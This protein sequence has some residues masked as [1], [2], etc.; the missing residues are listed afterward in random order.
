MY[1]AGICGH[2]GFGKDLANGQTVKTKNITS[3]LEKIYGEN[4]IYKMDSSGGKKQI[5]KICTEA[6]KLIKKCENIIMLPAHN[7]LLIFT[8]LFRFYNILFKRKLHYVV[9][10]GWLPEYMEK[11]KVTKRL[12][13]GFDK[14]Y[15]ETS[16]MKSKLENQGFNNVLVMPNF[17]HIK[18]IECK[19]KQIGL[20][21]KL[22]T[23]SRVLYEK[24]IEHAIEAVRLINQNGVTKCI[25]DIYGDVD[26][27]YK[28]HFESICNELPEY[29]RYMGCAD[30]QK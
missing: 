2:F 17:K 1:K 18:V 12:L 24:G 27:S 15:V 10:G 3:E 7:G 26:V 6:F 13:K 25:L 30:S 16:M 20:P 19:A 22:C 14:I 11:H 4:L 8:P 29:I 5:L 21:F 23:F 28:E 9:I